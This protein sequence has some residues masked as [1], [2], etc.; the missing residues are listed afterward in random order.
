MWLLL[1]IAE[2]VSLGFAVNLWRERA[3]L[4]RRLVWTPVVLVPVVGP[5]FYLGLFDVPPPLPAHLQLKRGTHKYPTLG[6]R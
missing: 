5:I 6:G 1:T 2:I 3:S 4:L